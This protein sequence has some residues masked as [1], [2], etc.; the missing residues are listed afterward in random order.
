MPYGGI[1]AT[2]STGDCGPPDISSTLLS[3]PKCPVSPEDRITGYEPVDAGSSPAR[4]ATLYASVLQR[5]RGWSKK[6]DVV[7]SN[8]T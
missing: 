2:V 5:K 1:G 8:L 7:G 4:G 6:P 3:H